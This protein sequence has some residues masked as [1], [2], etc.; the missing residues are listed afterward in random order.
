V[1]IL[2]P[3]LNFAF[4]DG[5]IILLDVERDRYFCLSEPLDRSLARV[6][7][8]TGLDAA[9]QQNLDRLVKR[10][11]LVEGGS[12]QLEVL[13]ALPPRL[14][15]LDV[16][17][18][19]PPSPLLTLNASCRLA[20]AKWL[21]R[22]LTLSDFLKRVY[23]T[24]FAQDPT[25]DAAALARIA[26]AFRRASFLSRTRDFCLPSSICLTV[27]LRRLGFPARLTLGVAGRPF[28][29]HCWVQV[30]D[31]VANDVLDHV[32]CFTPILVI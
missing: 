13:T 29:A 30:D 27:Y 11:I 12:V 2:R 31:I 16:C 32:V 3:G 5:R 10:D 14:S 6:L 4:A 8:Q 28:A 7:R 23:R 17:E 22:R 24:E 15:A 20:F 19:V 18:P 25:Y 21:H 26:F 9:D 1:L